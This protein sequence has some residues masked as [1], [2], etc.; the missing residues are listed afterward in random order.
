MIVMMLPAYQSR[1]MGEF[2]LSRRHAAVGWLGVAAML[3]AVATSFL[4]AS[5][6]AGHRLQKAGS[7]LSQPRWRK[8]Q[9][10]AMALATMS[11]SANG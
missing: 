11:P 1:V 5:R 7:H 2:T 4:I 6:Q 3:A 8:Y 10:G 9:N